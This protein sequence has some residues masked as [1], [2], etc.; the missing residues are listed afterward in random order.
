MTT[1]LLL[2]TLTSPGTDTAVHQERVAK[3]R[4]IWQASAPWSYS[5]ELAEFFVTEHERQCVGDQWWFSLIYGKANFGLTLHSR[6]PGLCFG[7]L[8]VKWPGFARQVGAHKPEDLRDPRLNI[9]AHVAEMAYYHRRTGETGT[10]L[11]AR[12]F[13][14]A[15][16]RYYHRWRSVAREHERYLRS[17]YQKR[18]TR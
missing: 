12:V 7:P 10:S 11:L 15:S 4:A 2:T 18:G 5:P 17:W 6:S 1:L 13:Y 14:P 8:D 16:P 3:C 9:R